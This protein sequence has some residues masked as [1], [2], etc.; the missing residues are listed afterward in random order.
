MIQI[1]LTSIPSNSELEDCAIPTSLSAEICIELVDEVSAVVLDRFC[2][3]LSGVIDRECS[4]QSGDS[5][6]SLVTGAPLTLAVGG[7]LDLMEAT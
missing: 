5:V 6:L 4:G 1:K 3:H 2:F 7:D